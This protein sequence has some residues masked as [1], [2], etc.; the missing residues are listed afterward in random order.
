VKQQSQRPDQSASALMSSQR[1]LDKLWFWLC[2]ALAAAFSAFGICAVGA[3]TAF[4]ALETDYQPP[5]TVFHLQNFE[6]IWLYILACIS[7]IYFDIYLL[8][9]TWMQARSATVP[10]PGAIQSEA[11][12]SYL[13]PALETS[14]TSSALPPSSIVVS[15]SSFLS[16]LSSTSTSPPYSMMQP[17]LIHPAPASIAWPTL[18]IAGALSTRTEACA[19]PHSLQSPTSADS[20]SNSNNNSNSNSNSNSNNRLIQLVDLSAP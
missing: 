17:E 2:V 12:F 3:A 11:A 19:T 6:R 13:P 16:S 5:Q 4:R 10:R 20:N 8:V 14:T 15:S 9:I 7:F 18:S 1:V